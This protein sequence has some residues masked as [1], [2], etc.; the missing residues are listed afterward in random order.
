MRDG[1][2]LST[3]VFEIAGS[4]TPTILVRSAYG[5]RGVD[6]LAS[7]VATRGYSVVVQATRGSLGSEGG[8]GLFLDDGWGLDEKGE[9]WD[10][11]DTIDWIARQ[12][13]CDGRVGMWGGSALGAA[14]YYAAATGHPALQCV[15]VDHAPWDIWRDSA[16]TGGGYRQGDIDLF[17]SFMAAGTNLRQSLLEREPRDDYWR[18][19]SPESRLEHFRIPIDHL[20]GWHDAFVEGT[21]AAFQQLQRGGGEGARGRQRLRIGPWTHGMMGKLE[22]GD[23]VFPSNSHLPG[24]VFMDDVAAWFDHWL[25]SKALGGDKPV[26]YYVMGPDNQPG[27]PGNVWREADSW[28]PPAEAFKLWLSADGSLR[29]K[30]EAAEAGDRAFRYD[31]N[32]P[33]PSWGGRNFLLPSGPRD[34]N[35]VEQGRSDL[36]VYRTDPLPIPLEIAGPVRLRLMA[37]SDRP[38]TDWTAKLVD[39]YPDGRALLV[40]DTLLRARFREGLD[41]VAPPLEPGR[42][43]DYDID[44]GNTAIAFDRGHRVQLTIASAAYPRFAA[45]PNTGA[46]MS[47]ENGEKL[48]ATNAIRHGSPDG[49]VLILPAAPGSVARHGGRATLGGGIHRDKSASRP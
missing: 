6:F 32:D 39:V 47:V 3:E 11:W 24:D 30:L 43:Y 31:P 22:Q 12:P 17:L 14:A 46:P 15:R 7:P 8:R 10:G 37:S 38:D 45:N 25:R 44:V 20:G 1:T 40:M 29:P 13:W 33:T 35:P 36:L 18:R 49:S 4:K 27:A 19:V 34:Q 16:R 26:V 23:L 2:K 42:F 48:I 28:P 41:K 21:I 9:H 5:N